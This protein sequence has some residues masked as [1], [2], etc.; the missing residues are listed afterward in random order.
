MQ[1][2]TNYNLNQWDATD[3]VTR[4]DFNADNAAIDTALK[5]NA[6]AVAGAQSAA[7][8]AQTAAAACPVVKLLEYTVEEASTTVTVDLSGIDFTQYQEVWFYCALTAIGN[9]VRITLNNRNDAIYRMSSNSTL[10]YMF[11]VFASSENAFRMQLRFRDGVVD[12]HCLT[13]MTYTGSGALYTTRVNGI[14][15]T[16]LRS[17]QFTCKN[18][19]ETIAAG[20]TMRM[21]G[22]KK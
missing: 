19:G 21:Y 3:R 10:T 12:G 4:E 6:D 8:A 13:A 14:D 15:D 18:A 20:G 2:T 7:A 22:L 5:A 17:M 11:E 1:H 9:Y 16:S